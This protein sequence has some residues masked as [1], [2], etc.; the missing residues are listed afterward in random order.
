MFSRRCTSDREERSEGTENNLDIISQKSPAPFNDT[1]QIVDR[2][3]IV[4]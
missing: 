2:A 3:R 1:V 4:C